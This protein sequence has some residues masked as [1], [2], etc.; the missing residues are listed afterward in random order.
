VKV[1]ITRVIPE[2]AFQVALKNTLSHQPGASFPVALQ[3]GDNAKLSLGAVSP[4]P[5]RQ[6]PGERQDLLPTCFAVGALISMS[7]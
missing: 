5:V 4:F 7:V 3:E 1:G 2:P 6:L